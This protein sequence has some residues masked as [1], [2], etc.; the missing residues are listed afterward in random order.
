MKAEARPRGRQRSLEA[1]QAILSAALDLLKE[2]P[3]RDVTSD[4]IAQ[5]AGVSKATLYKWWPNKSA[6]A[7]DALMLRVAREASTPDTGSA[8]GDFTSQIRQVIRFLGSPEGSVVRQL[9]AEGQ[10]DPDFLARFHERF[11]KTRRNLVRVLL[12]RAVRRGELRKGVDPEL[13]LD[14]IFG[15]LMY[16]LLLGHAPL[17]D[18]QAEAMVQAAFRGLQGDRSIAA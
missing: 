1:E 10:S 18:T 9:I 12:E 16:R 5:R 2:K 17:D 14:L 13:A 3:L 4:A 11:S 8:V 15:P 6:I 7:L